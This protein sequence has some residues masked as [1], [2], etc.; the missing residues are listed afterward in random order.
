MAASR[1][2]LV[3]DNHADELPAVQPVVQDLQQLRNRM[4]V[5]LDHVH[6]D[7]ERVEALLIFTALLEERIRGQAPAETS[8][9]DKIEAHPA[10]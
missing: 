1:T 9:K 10:A 4:R 5:A 8:A 7:L 3:T 2:H 6:A